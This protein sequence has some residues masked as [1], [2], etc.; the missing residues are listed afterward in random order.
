MKREKLEQ[1][2]LQVQKPAHYIGGELNSVMK[3]KTR[4]DCRLAFCFPDKYE[5]G[6]SHLGMKILY[7]L[8]NQRE[9][10]WCERVFA[11]DADME[12]LLR[13]EGEPLYALESLDPIKDFD[14]ILFTLQYEMSYTGVLNMLD[15]AGVPVLAKERTGL[16]PI[17]A[18]GGPCACNP[19][20]LADF[21]DLF[22]LG[23]GEEVNLE[24]TD[25]YMQ[26]KKEGWDKQ[27][28]LKEAAKIGGVYVP[29]LYDVSYN[30]DGTIHAVTPNC[31][32]APAKVTKRIIADLDKVFFPEKFVVPFI[33]I[34]H[35]R[36]MLELQRGCLR[37][38][39][40][41][42]AGFIYRPLREKHY[43][44]LNHDA[45]CLCDTSGYE[46][47]SLTSLS[48]S[49][50]LEIEPLL[51][52]LLAW[53]PQQRVSLSLP[54][55]RVDNFS[56]ELMEKVSRIKKSGLTFAAE[57]GT[58]RLRDVINKNVTEEEVL[59]TCKTAFEGGYTSVKLYFM[60]GLP[61]E[62]M[63]DIEGIAN[64]AQKVVDLYYS[65]PTRPKGRSV[66]VS[67]SCACFVP[68]P[69]TP[70]QFEGQDTMELL[71]E[72]QKHLLASVKSKKISVSYHDADVSFIEA[73]LAKG[74]RRMGP[75][76]LSAWKKGSKLDGWY[77]YFDPQRW[78]DAMAECG[79]DP[80]FYAN[81]HRDYDEVMPWDHLDFCVSKEFLIR[82]NKIARQSA[83]TPQC[84]ECCSAC[85]ANCLTGG[86][87]C[88]ANVDTIT[89]DRPLAPIEPV[90]RGP[91][92]ATLLEQ[93]Q[94]MRLFFTK[95]DRAKYISHLDMNRCMSRAMRRADLPVW[96]TGG[97]NPHMYLTFPL[98]LSLGCESSYE[99]VDL[100]MVQAV[101]PQ[102][103]VG[104]LNP[105]L[106]P[107]IQVFRAAAPQMDQKEIAWAD[108]EMQL[109]GGENFAEKLE[110]YLNQPAIMVVKKTKK[111]E[112]EIDIR[113]HFSVQKL[114]V[115]DGGVYATMRFAT[116]IEL[117][118]NP[119]LLLDN[120]PFLLRVISL[121]RVMVYNKELQPFC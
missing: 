116:G 114:E 44:T 45:H 49:D 121:K 22:I 4:V 34:V 96:Y 36:S 27:R 99:C 71:R 41:C 10:W 87:R 105:C 82:E 40:F 58:Q 62:T 115:R 48:T 81:R 43:D 91:D 16:W 57:A 76:I 118:I 95:L 26:A 9:N 92:P 51:D 11:P 59:S 21:V 78:Y 68:K 108:Y 35:D 85:G 31:P 14:F 94:K 3:D 12:A 50:Y 38:C 97:F 79:L 52:D 15:L 42:Q 74:D 113:P 65:L 56:K 93:P 110:E 107:D 104:R 120:A 84:R 54:S 100:K 101:D 86:G 111:G 13:K 80:A 25:L 2:L 89:S 63:E 23:E 37:G 64:L 33:N 75:V 109:A 73:I 77:E 61:T 70:F 66:S 6:M 83:T 24:I 18:A 30:D 17:V 46:E 1:I 112:K 32:E 103:V 39:R 106:P 119:T 72:K 88:P 53:T 60:M 7:S 67:I 5:V 90:D 69:F 8:Y 19:E 29:S 28:Y 98:P 20:P 47:L 102:E 117:N 55:L